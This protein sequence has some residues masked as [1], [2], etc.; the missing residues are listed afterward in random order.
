[1]MK[2]LQENFKKILQIYSYGKN[3]YEFSFH[4]RE[5]I[6]STPILEKGM[7][8]FLYKDMESKLIARKKSFQFI[9]DPPTGNIRIDLEKKLILTGTISS[10]DEVFGKFQIYEDVSLY[11]M[12]A[13]NGDYEHRNGVYLFRN[14]DTLFYSLKNQSYS[15][16]PV[17]FFRKQNSQKHFAI[18]FYT[19]YPVEVE[20]LVNT[21]QNP[22]IE[23]IARYYHKRETEIVDFFLITGSSEEIITSL[24]R[25]FGF[26]FF[27]PVW[28][29]GYHQSRWSYKTQKKVLEIANESSRHN[30][31][32]DAIYLDIHYMD[33]YRVFTW[34]RKR[35]PDPKKLIEELH[36]K[37]IKLVTIIDPCIAV[38][39]RYQP[40]REGV[41]KEYFCKSTNG[42]YTGKLW[43][44]L[45]H[46]PDFTEE[47][48]QDWWA[49]LHKELLES[50]VDGIWNDMN[51][52][53]FRVGSTKEPLKEPVIHKKGS[54]LKFRNIYANLENMAT[55]KAFEKFAP[56]KRHFL[57]SRS[58]FLGLQKHAFLW[59]GDNHT[60]WEHLR[61]NL[62]MIINLSLSGIFYAGADI[63]GFGAPARG[64]FALFKLFRNPELFERW[65]EL[66]SLLPFFRNHTVLFSYAQEPWKFPKP[67]INRVR[68]HIRRRYQLLF[69]LYYLFYEASTKG[70]PVIR[71]L[72]YENGEL[73]VKDEQVK[74][75]F[76]IGS[77]LMACPV[78]YPGLLHLNVYLPYGEW[79]EF[80]TGKVYRGNQWI[81][82]PVPRG[83]YPLF[84]KAGSVIPVAIPRSNAEDTLQGEIIMEVY[85]NSKIEGY[86]Y[87]DDGITLQYKTR[88]FLAKIEGKKESNQSL[89]L[90]YEILCD[91]YK[92]KENSLKLRVPVTYTTLIDNKKKRNGVTKNL[93][94]EDRN[95]SV[96]EFE[97][98]L[99]ENWEVVVMP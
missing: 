58:G 16:I 49:N 9:F 87:L 82:F 65:I 18:V 36:A 75:Q 22:K 99:K 89:T 20:V 86:L 94:Q 34:N 68:K 59:T 80:E 13:I 42:Y 4:G 90:K 24:S 3:I 1:M 47:K 7:E 44:G 14:I 17:F 27:P 63:G 6:L 83:Y 29:L 76:F 28:A 48:V 51:E 30:I 2:D 37:K 35:F 61:E 77:H 81:D 93:S 39:T 91:T 96:S 52:P 15:S 62:Y 70:K 10:K 46:Y 95:F 50:G 72:F 19:S 53:V 66:G 79:Y 45:V 32:L 5:E 88:Y 25:L 38:D 23:I 69:Y 33:R 78:L 43:S 84:I 85:P 26:P 57:L 60:S 11:G 40:Y 73:P 8:V 54:H 67:T 55:A 56:S 21:G 98:P 74:H 92:P 97:M 31:P 71:P 64:I 12:G 41:E